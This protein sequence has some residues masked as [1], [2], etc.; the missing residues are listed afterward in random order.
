MAKITIPEHEREINE[1]GWECV[2]VRC[3]KDSEPHLSITGN[4]IL[5]QGITYTPCPILHRKELRGWDWVKTLP[6]NSLIVHG[7][8]IFWIQHNTIGD[9]HI[10]S[11]DAMWSSKNV[12]DNIN[13]FIHN[14]SL[15]TCRIVGKDGVARWH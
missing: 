9:T 6:D 2:E 4:P 15:S 11:W 5:N 13:T 7:C 1:E 12:Y 8:T 3:A 10:H 14:F